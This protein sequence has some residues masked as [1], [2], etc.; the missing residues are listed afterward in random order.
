MLRNNNDKN[1][2]AKMVGL[3]NLNLELIKAYY[4]GTKE[5]KRMQMIQYKTQQNRGKH[6]CDN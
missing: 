3:E 1:P 4:L 5:K 2:C 6:Q